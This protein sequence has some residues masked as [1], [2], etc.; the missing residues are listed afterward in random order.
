MKVCGSLGIQFSLQ[1]LEYKLQ[2]LVSLVAAPLYSEAATFRDVSFVALCL[3]VSTLTF[4]QRMEAAFGRGAESNRVLFG[5]SAGKRTATI[6]GQT[7]P[8]F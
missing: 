7:G 1:A 2:T 4:Y 6:M 5:R 3:D 8:L